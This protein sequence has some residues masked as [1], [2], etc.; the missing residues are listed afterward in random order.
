[1]PDEEKAALIFSD[2]VEF[3]NRALHIYEQVGNA[4]FYVRRSTPPVF[5][6]MREIVPLQ[7]ADIVAY[8]MHKEFE[9]QLYKPS[10]DPRFGYERILKMSN[11]AGYTNPL[12]RYFTKADLAMHVEQTEKV[13]RFVRA[14]F[15]KLRAKS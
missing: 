6:D 10:V 15:A 11:R 14:Q 1:V 2:Q 12:F 3:K 13:T 9:R 4:N 8:E 7:A 5:R